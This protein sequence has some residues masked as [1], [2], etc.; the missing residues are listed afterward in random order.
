MADWQHVDLFWSICMVHSLI[1]TKAYTGTVH[2]GLHLQFSYFQNVIQKHCFLLCLI[3]FTSGDCVIYNDLFCNSCKYV[4]RNLTLSGLIHYISGYICICY[5]NVRS[6]RVKVL[7]I[8]HC[9]F[10]H[11]EQEIHL[12]MSVCIYIVFYFCVCFLPGGRV[13]FR[14]IWG[15]QTKNFI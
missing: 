12:K 13:G 4:N 15:R 6:E 1:F 11:P 3:W 10:R 7:Q 8:K 9:Y 14:K 2:C 5:Q